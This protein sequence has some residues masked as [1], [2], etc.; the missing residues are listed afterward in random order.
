MKVESFY[1]FF[2]ITPSSYL[3]VINSENLLYGLL[4]KKKITEEMAD[5]DLS[6]IEYETVPE[7]F[8]EK[9]MNESLLYYFHSHK[10]IPVLNE[11]GQRI[12]NWDK[13]RFLSEFSRMTDMP[14]AEK[15]Q[16][17]EK[18]QESEPTSEIP[19]NRLMIFKFMELILRNFP[20]A[21]FAADREGNTTFYNEKFETDVL[22]KPIF[23]DSI[24]FAEKY[25]KELNQ[26][27]ISGFFKSV[28][29]EPP[30]SIPVLQTY[31]KNLDIYVR[32]IT[33]KGEEK[34]LGYL[35]HFS[36][37][38]SP[39][40]SGEMSFPI[41]ESVFNSGVPL[42]E[43]LKDVESVYIYKS[44]KKNNENIS[45][46]AQALGLPRSTLQNRI[47][48]LGLDEKLD[49]NPG[50]PIPRNRKSISDRENDSLESDELLELVEEKAEKE[51]SS[52]KKTKN[53][54]VGKNTKSVSKKK[55]A[56]K[57][58]SSLR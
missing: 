15:I 21:L 23:R 25:F 30:D 57:K 50:T 33:L 8:L 20:D 38:E 12:D 5:L 13:T 56:A 4:S 26:D 45:H 16:E 42:Q 51:I 37:P 2:L 47:R 54:N 32:V 36:E 28:E 11:N 29:E 24:G 55:K 1:K 35:Y 52:S 40:N 41:L 3:P 46:T 27:L 7:H 49:R 58:K 43:I 39:K 53:K 34:V 18:S 14:K 19:S 17:K 6:G 22:S 31:I 44:F 9:E 48:H 10:T